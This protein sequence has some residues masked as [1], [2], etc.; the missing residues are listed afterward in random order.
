LKIDGYMLRDVWPAL[1]SLSIHVTFTAIV[2]GVYPWEAKMCKNCAKM[3][4]FG[5]YSL[6]YWETVEDR[7]VHAAMRL[8]SIE[9]SFDPCN[10]YRDCPRGVSR[11]KQNVVKK[12]SF[13]HEYC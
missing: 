13:A 1:N 8:T 6:N 12:R 5:F 11:R 9:F 2:L 10:I 3:A 4:T 7:W